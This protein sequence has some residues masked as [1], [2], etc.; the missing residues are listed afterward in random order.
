MSAFG[1]QRRE[2]AWPNLTPMIDV[3]FLLVVFFMLTAA[4]VKRPGALDVR[5]P[6]ASAPAR[7]LEPTDL[8][9]SLAASGALEVDGVEVAHDTLGPYLSKRATGAEAS[10]VVLRADGE[11]RHAEVVRVLDTV[12]AEGIRSIAIATDPARANPLTPDTA[13]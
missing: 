7:A 6:V 12:R 4:F 9:V 2:I 1:R 10:R 8:V 13:R 11:V 3:V 5:L